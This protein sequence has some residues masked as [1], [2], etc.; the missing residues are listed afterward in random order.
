MS[1]GEFKDS[2]RISGLFVPV[3]IVFAVTEYWCN[4][5][6]LSL[7]VFIYEILQDFQRISSFLDDLQKF[8]AIKATF[9]NAEF[10]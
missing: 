3:E 5:R 9:H 10:V 2:R 1:F 4:C 7:V 6:F 8:C